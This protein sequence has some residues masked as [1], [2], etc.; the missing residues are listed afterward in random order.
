MS[1]SR[2][3]CHETVSFKLRYITSCS[4]FNNEC[5]RFLRQCSNCRGY[6]GSDPHFSIWPSFEPPTSKHPSHT[7]SGQGRCLT[8]TSYGT[9]QAMICEPSRTTQLFGG[10]GGSFRSIVN[11]GVIFFVFSLLW[12]NSHLSHLSS[13][14]RF[15]F[16]FDLIVLILIVLV[17]IILFLIAFLFGINDIRPLINNTLYIILTIWSLFHIHTSIAVDE[18]INKIKKGYELPDQSGVCGWKEWVER[19]FYVAWGDWKNLCCSF[20]IAQWRRN[21]PLP[22][23]L[24]PC[25]WRKVTWR[26]WH[27][28]IY[29]FLGLCSHK[30]DLVR[31]GPLLI[32]SGGLIGY[33]I[34]GTFAGSSIFGVYHDTTSGGN[35]TR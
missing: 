18:I 5:C 27:K 6:R 10:G 16:V 20:G 13:S 15:C 35:S 19:V 24:P 34:V 14:P 1:L 23:Q 26:T 3:S 9:S 30:E 29:I 25:T 33:I 17:L 31:R 12:E 4:L 8:S 11:Q 21:S 28:W 7:C 22:L 2:W 32:F